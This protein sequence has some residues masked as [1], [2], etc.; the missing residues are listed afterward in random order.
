VL[1]TLWLL[2][3]YNKLSLRSIMFMSVSK[4]GKEYEKAL[5]NSAKKF[6]G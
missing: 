3:N 4:G 2:W 5:E 6:S 1:K